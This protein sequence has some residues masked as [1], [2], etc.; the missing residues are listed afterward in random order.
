MLCRARYTFG[1]IRPLRDVKGARRRT[2]ATVYS[3]SEYRRILFDI[4]ANILYAETMNEANEILIKPLL[5]KRIDLTVVS[6]TVSTSDDLKAA[7]R[8]GASDYTTLIAKRQVG[9]RGREGRRFYSEGGLYMS[10]LLPWRGDSAPFITQIAAIAVARALQE[11]ARVTPT[12][13]WVNDLFVNGKKVCGIL[14]ESVIAG[15]ERRIVVGIGVNAGVP[16]TA[17]PDELKEIAGSVACDKNLLTAALLNQLF[18]LLDDFSVES[19]REDYRARCF[20]IGTRL[21]V[22]KGEAERK[23]TARGLDDALGLIVEY[24]DGTRERLIS[25]EVRVK[26]V[27]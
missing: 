22:I 19:V 4:P 7:A 20:P 10:V 5:N 3:L 15:E 21:T 2:D 12:I 17:F 8:A 14:A 18:A 24:D 11:T 13:K 23:A 6:E 16:E 1:A 27:L 9:G 26:V 25:G